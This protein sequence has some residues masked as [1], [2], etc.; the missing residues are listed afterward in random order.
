MIIL[1]YAYECIACMYVYAPC[2]YLV[3]SEARKWCQITLNW[4]YRQLLAVMWVLEIELRSSGRTSVFFNHWASSIFAFWNRVLCN[5]EHAMWLRM[6][7]NSFSCLNFP[8]E[9]MIIKRFS[10]H[11][12]W[13][14]SYSNCH[15][16]LPSPI[17]L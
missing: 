13:G 5:L 14:H 2:M 7:L 16:L 10:G 9:I 15:I 3:P 1:F 8:I 12:Q 11:W 6:A 17:G 4:S